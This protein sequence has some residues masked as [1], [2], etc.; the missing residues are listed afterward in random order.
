MTMLTSGK[1]SISAKMSPRVALPRLALRIL[2]PSAPAQTLPLPA[3]KCT[4]GSSERCHIHLPGGQVQPLHCLIV[5]SAA[6]TVVK[7][8]AHGVRLN[9][10]N[11]TSAAFHPGDSLTIGEVQLQLVLQE[12]AQ[13]FESPIEAN[14]V[15]ESLVETVAPSSPHDPSDAVPDTIAEAVVKTDL[16]RPVDAAS[17]LESDRLVRQ[18]WTANYGA[19]QRCRKLVA[20]LRDVR[21]QT[22]LFDQQIDHLEDQLRTVLDDREQIT[23]DL[24]Q[25]QAEA[26]ERNEEITAEI[27]RLISELNTANQQRCIA[28]ESTALHEAES[29][30][31]RSE[32]TALDEQREQLLQARSRDE[33]QYSE[34][35]QTLA[36]RDHRIGELQGELDQQRA[37][38]TSAEEHSAEQTA[39]SERLQA[40]LDQLQAER[41]H[42]LTTQSEQQQRQHEWE[43]TL[44]DRDHRIGELQGELDQQRASAT[45]AEEHSAEQTATS[46]RLQTELD[47]LQVEREHLLTAQSEQEQRQH[48]WEQAIEDRDRRIDELQA[49]FD[50]TCQALQSFEKSAFD[51]LDAY[52]KLEE[53][54]DAL[55]TERDHL[56]EG[57]TEREQHLH[58]L[59]QSLVDRDHRIGD[60]SE[61]LVAAD[62]QR[63]LLEKEAADRV[64]IIENL[65]TET[66]ELRT[67]CE[68]LS[69]EHTS[70]DQRQQELQ[71]ALAD[72]QLRTD[73]L[74]EDLNTALEDREELQQVLDERIRT[75]EKLQAELAERHATCE[76]LSA[77]RTTDGEQRARFQQQL[78]ERQQRIELLEVDVQTAHAELNHSTERVTRLEEERTE[79]DE[80]ILAQQ[81]A[82]E[83]KDSQLAGMRDLES[84]LHDQRRERDQLTSA[85]DAAKQELDHLRQQTDSHSDELNASHQRVET[86]EAEKASLALRVEEQTRQVDQRSLELEEMRVLLAE[87][88][89]QIEEL[90][91]RHQQTQGELD[92]VRE[93]LQSTEQAL[94]KQLKDIVEEVAVVDS[95]DENTDEDADQRMDGAAESR[96]AISSEPTLRD[97]SPEEA[98]AHLRELSVWVEKDD[99]S[100]MTDENHNATEVP[101]PEKFKPTSYIDQYSHLLEEGNGQDSELGEP[102]SPGPRHA[103]PDLSLGNT[104]NET[105]CDDVPCDESEDQA[106]EAYMS[107]L[108]RRVRG[109]SVSEEVAAPLLRAGRCA[110]SIPAV[111]PVAAVDIV[112]ERLAKCDIS[113]ELES[114]GP[115]DLDELKRASRKPPLKADLSAM[116]ELANRSARQ[117]IAKHRKRRHLEMALGKF[118]ICAIATG[119]AI[120]MSQSSKTYQSP[121]FIASWAA[122]V[123]AVLWG[124][125]FLNVCLETIR[126]GSIKKRIPAEIPVE[127]EPLPIDG[128]AENS[129]DL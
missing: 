19:R 72:H 23:G 70:S 20:S 43:Q 66:A 28:Q 35:E 86:L 103:S 45:S 115:I 25:A 110:S 9:G 4:I 55:R 100:S 48:E 113:L 125:K 2:Q 128:N 3:G 56:A 36:D 73:E 124:G 42:L 18:L 79:A 64:A 53:Q 82:L 6:E 69:E 54:L 60:L 78:A 99:A 83:S 84:V 114:Q 1:T 27:D 11:F 29:E 68:Q 77:E 34:L 12:D 33:H 85:L 105:P 10:N 14:S 94:Q 16:E 62:N 107:N 7:R 21:D 119:T 41:E 13:P 51:Q 109:E 97:R 118:I 129:G 38:A 98:L 15:G 5:H 96:Q 49:N 121:G 40:E 50:Q 26:A 71:R 63:D 106:L 87:D 24:T 120:Y 95:A 123:V 80:R 89:T 104:L 31:F 93:C 75:C 58:N 111:D 47:Q 39:T 108:M 101:T 102:S 59:E 122:V 32:L 90:H 44:A 57:Q 46:V 61:Q 112:A 74:C 127:Q 52:K 65:E 88:Q 117:A 37:S 116:R 8:W 91:Q 67:R 76:Q 81:E 92:D 30:R 17:Q 22:T 126:E